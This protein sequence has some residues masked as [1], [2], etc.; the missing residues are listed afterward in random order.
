M[1]RAEQDETGWHVTH[2][3]QEIPVLRF[4]D[5][6]AVARDMATVLNWAEQDRQRHEGLPDRD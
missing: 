6:A 4:Y 2:D 3:G 1:Y 5:G